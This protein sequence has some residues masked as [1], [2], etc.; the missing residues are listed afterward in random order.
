ML[1]KK[2]M[3]LLVGRLV[4]SCIVALCAAP[5][6]ASPETEALR[7]EL[8]RLKQRMEELEAR[9]EASERSTVDAKEAV[10]E[11]GTAE[12]EQ[13]AIEFGG[14]LRFNYV[15]KDFDD[16]S[17]N[18]RGDA[19]LDLFRVNADGELDNFLLSAEY[20]FYSFMDTIHH[21]WIGYDF[22]EAGQVQL[23]ITKVPF[24]LLPYASHNFWFGIPY[25][26][27][28]ADDYDMGL[29]Y[30]HDIGPWNVQ[31]AFFKNAEFSDGAELERYSYDPVTVGV[32]R[33]EQVNSLSG[34]LAY[35]LARGSDCTH[36]FG[37]SGLWG[38]LHNRDTDQKGD[39]WAAAAHVDSR[40]GRWNLQ[41]EGGRYAYNPRNPTG[42]SDK[43]ITF[44]AFKATHEVA[45]TANFGVFNVAYNLPVRWPGVDLITCYNDFSLLDKSPNG[46]DN[47]YLNTTGCA[48]GVG[49]TFTY[50]D[51]I[52]GKNALFLGDGS[53]AGD[54]DDDWATRY[55]INLGYY[56]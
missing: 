23:G 32:A 39:Y 35:T 37:G 20:R 29:K 21:G 42:I 27:G 53:L 34:R 17:E 24:G 31:F 13:Q 50:I 44:G 51:I 6:R 47:S 30:L 41:L 25:Y 22:D 45:S 18:R 3:A 28:L 16:E 52:R 46:F 9:I 33:N 8:E 12:D 1:T 15:W 10:S 36:E 56:W 49:P 55:N 4:L 48:V 38:Q 26:I 2:A 14:A 40:C 7:Q 5:L 43:S 19:G 11:A 54:G